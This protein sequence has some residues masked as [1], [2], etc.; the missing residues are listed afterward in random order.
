MTP[1]RPTSGDSGDSD[2]PRIG[3]L[4]DARYRIVALIGVGGMGA[5]YR[6]K[7]EKRG[8]LVALKLLAAERASLPELGAR[9]K[10]EAAAGKRINHPNVIAIHDSGELKDGSLWF[11]MEL[12]EGKS[13]DKVLDQGKLPIDRAVSIVKQMLAG[14]DAAHKL[15]IAHRDVKPENVMLV[16]RDGRETVKLLD[17]GLASNDRAAIKLTV[18]GSAF[19]TP[20][21]ISPEMAMGLPADPRADLYSV[22]VVLF[23]MVTGHLPFAG[24]EWRDL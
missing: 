17:F 3:Q 2:D 13:L 23:Q 24:K 10:R 1:P 4:I 6:A 5:V 20:E 19:G 11:V 9:F 22:G 12:L 18:A 15:G 7:D 8:D 21:Y 16:E 14:L